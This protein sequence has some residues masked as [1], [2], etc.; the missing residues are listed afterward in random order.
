[1]SNPNYLNFLFHIFLLYNLFL[2][3]QASGILDYSHDLNSEL[4]IQAGALSSLDNVIPFSYAKL[5]ICDSKKIVKVEDTLG[6]I[7]TGERI[8]STGYSAL[9]GNDSFC[10]ILCYNEFDNDSIN[11]IKRLIKGNYFVN[12][13]LDKLPAGILSY[14]K[15]TKETN[16]DYFKGIPL[17]YLEND[18]YYINNHL[19]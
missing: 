15:D 16:I 1:M 6:E 8:F 12:W 14:N 4:Q 13:Y 11:L 17:G 5:K 2:L 9:T 7:L 3:I 10:Q 19:K 18:I